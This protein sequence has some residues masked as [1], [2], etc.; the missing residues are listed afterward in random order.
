[1]RWLFEN[2]QLLFIIGG[3][4]AFWLNQRRKEKQD[5]EMAEEA[6]RGPTDDEMAERTRRIQEEIRRKIEERR[7]QSP[8]EVPPAAEWA[9][10]ETPPAL[11][12]E[13]PPLLPPQR[14]VLVAQEDASGAAELDRVM[15]EQRRYAEQLERLAETERART[16]ALARDSAMVPLSMAAYSTALPATRG[17]RRADGIFALARDRESLRRAIVLRE[18]LGAPKALR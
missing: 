2:P 1:M 10:R 12:A 11:P 7:G 16:E 13:P 18:V 6:A 3:A 15:E 14:P 8:L 9:R 17:A 4:I 5:R